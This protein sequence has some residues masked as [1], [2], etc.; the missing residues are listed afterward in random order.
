MIKLGKLKFEELNRPVV[1]ENLSGAKAEMIRQE[2][3]ALREVG[4]RKAATPRDEVSIAK[5]KKG[6]ASGSLT[7]EGLKERLWKP[8]KEEEKKTL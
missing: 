2:E 6:E 8:N 1:V 3:K 5:D 7:T 4:F